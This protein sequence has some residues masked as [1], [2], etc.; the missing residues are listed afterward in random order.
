MNVKRK[1]RKP[2]VISEDIHILLSEWAKKRGFTIPP[3]KFFK[4]LRQEMQEYFEKIFGVG[5]VDMVSASELKNGMLSLIKRSGLP[6]ISMD[7]VY[8]RT[9]PDIQV[10]RMVDKNLIDQGIGPRYGTLPIDKQL[11]MI[12]ER[13]IALVDDVLFSGKVMV[14]IIKALEKRGVK[15]PI[16]IAGIAVG[17]GVQR[18]QK[19]TDS[20]ILSVRYYKEVIDE[21][22]ERDFYPGVPLSGRSLLGKANI[23]YPYIYPFGKVCAW[24]SIPEKYAKEFSCFCLYQSI[25]LWSAIE[26]V[27][28]KPVRC[29]DLERLPK[30]AWCGEDSLFTQKLMSE[31]KSHCTQEYGA[32]DYIADGALAH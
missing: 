19:Q 31:M 32:I 1:S 29:R 18:I 20:Q 13:E 17:E 15:V 23:G 6:A 5:N 16:V 25:Y 2:Y 11:S 14:K 10:T 4:Q 7:R 22:C 30:E 8:I 24:A 27:S 28:A 12:R 21:I 9:T 26:A 3:A